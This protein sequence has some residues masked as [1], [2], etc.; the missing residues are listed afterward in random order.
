MSIRNNKN[1]Y[2]KYMREYHI[3]RYYRLRNQ[4]LILLGNKCRVCG[5]KEKLQIDHVNRKFKSFEVTRMLSVSLKR[6]YNEIKKCQILC[7][8]CHAD[9]TALELGKK[10]ARNTHGTLSSYRYCKCNICKKVNSD[11]MKAYWL[12]KHAR[13]A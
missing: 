2:N 1:E 3:Q 7:Q 12:K 4:A 5:S 10:I 8:T 11:Y 6:F 9:K 13:L